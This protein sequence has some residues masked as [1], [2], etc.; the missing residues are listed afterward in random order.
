M[1]S[2]LLFLRI[3]GDGM[4][5]FFFDKSATIDRTKKIILCACV[6]GIML[7]SIVVGAI[8]FFSF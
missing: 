1:R 8:F 2:V 5:F 4:L 6:V 7:V 3:D